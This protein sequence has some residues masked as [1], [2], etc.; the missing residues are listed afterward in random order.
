MTRL[1]TNTRP[2]ARAV[3]PWI[4]G[5][6][7]AKNISEVMDAYR[8]LGWNTTLE[9]LLTAH[10]EQSGTYATI[11]HNGDGSRTILGNKLGPDYKILQNINMLNAVQQL[12]DAGCAIKTVGEVENGKRVWALSEIPGDLLIG[13]EDILKRFIM[14]TNDHCGRAKATVELLATRL[15][16]T[17]GATITQT[18]GKMRLRHMGNLDLAFTNVM[19]TVD[20]A[21]QQFLIYGDKMDKLTQ[22]KNIN[23]ADVQRYVKQVMFPSLTA[24]DQIDKADRIRTVT[25]DI[26]RLFESGPGAETVD[27][28]G[29]AYGLYHAVNRYLNYDVRSSNRQASLVFGTNAAID[30]RALMAAAQLVSAA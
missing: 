24:Q 2:D 7:G 29:T 15:V 1:I 6:G 14:I 4:R 12:H 9:Q 20:I 3:E 27:A 5:M 19:E 13:A 23:Q 11:R 28:K 10:G 21:N 8:V 17:N 16:C 18:T 22:F 25:R 30:A 26:T